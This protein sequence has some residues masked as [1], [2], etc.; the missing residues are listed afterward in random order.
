M[1]AGLFIGFAA[2]SFYFIVGSPMTLS[3]TG[4]LLTLILA[5]ILTALIF[6]DAKERRLPNSGTFTLIIIGLLLPFIPGGFSPGIVKAL[7]G[8]VAGI[9]FV[10]ILRAFFLYFRGVEAIGM[11]DAKMIGAIGAWFGPFSLAPSLALASLMGLSFWVIMRFVP[12]QNQVNKDGEAQDHLDSEQ[13]IAF[14]PFLGIA[15]WLLWILENQAGPTRFFL[16]F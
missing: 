15:F 5:Y 10:L 12:K 13:A 1:A 9:G 16:L 6:V 4:L 3:M 11:G 8:L 2:T 7:I 14:G